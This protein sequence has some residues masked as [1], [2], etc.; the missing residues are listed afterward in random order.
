MRNTLKDS[1]SQ[2]KDNKI[3]KDD[4][5]DI[6]DKIKDSLEDIISSDVDKKRSSEKRKERDEKKIKDRK[7]VFKLKH[8]LR[9]LINVF[10]NLMHLGE[11][12]KIQKKY[13][14]V[15][16]SEYLDDILNA[17][18]LK[19]QNIFKTKYAAMKKKIGLN[20]ILNILLFYQ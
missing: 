12:E 1:M 11:I 8:P 19:M 16:N 5:K 14:E 9:K 7:E 6:S 4:K 18:N 3:S 13:N 10:K 15:I 2:M 20:V 17:G